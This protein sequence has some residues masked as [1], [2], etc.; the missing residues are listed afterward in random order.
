VIRTRDSKYINI[1][2]SYV[3]VTCNSIWTIYAAI[4]MEPCMF[5]ACLISV[6]FTVVQ[7]MFYHWAVGNITEENCIMN[8]LVAFFSRPDSQ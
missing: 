1:S 2:L 4:V 8:H 5:S 6:I 3:S 7:I